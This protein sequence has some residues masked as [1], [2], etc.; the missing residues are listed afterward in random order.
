MIADPDA[1]S[2]E[3]WRSDALNA[4]TDANGTDGLLDRLRNGDL[5]RL[6]GIAVNLQDS[7][8]AKARWSDTRD[9]VEKIVESAKELAKALRALRDDERDL[10]KGI[11][12]FG[13]FENLF[14]IGHEIIS[15]SQLAELQ[16]AINDRDPDEKKARKL[17]RSQ[18]LFSER[19]QRYAQV[20]D[21]NAMRW[22]PERNE[23]HSA[24]LEKELGALVDTVELRWEL[25]SAVAKPGGGRSNLQTRLGASPRKIF[26]RE[27]AKIFDTE[28]LAVSE[29]EGGG[30]FRFCAAIYDQAAGDA[31]F[32]RDKPFREIARALKQKRK[33]R[34]IVRE[35]QAQIEKLPGTVHDFLFAPNQEALPE[36][37]RLTERQEDAQKTNGRRAPG[38]LGK[39]PGCG[40]LWLALTDAREQ[41]PACL[42]WDGIA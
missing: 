18:Q 34:T 24:S 2:D 36:F 20:D 31:H 19:F 23:E 35:I 22:F 25:L 37:F 10:L 9:R 29:G 32:S 13:E 12:P 14:A 1:S 6:L 17:M 26:V 39:G 42:A 33:N 5:D 4:I 21:P 8:G 41:R 16:A 40:S 15:D 30:F 28:D 27:C 3:Q 38:D 7:E 11:D